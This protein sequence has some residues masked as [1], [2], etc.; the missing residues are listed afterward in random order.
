MRVDPIHQNHARVDLCHDERQ[1]AVDQ[2][3]I[4]ACGPHPHTSLECP[5]QVDAIEVPDG[6]VRHRLCVP[7]IRPL[8]DEVIKV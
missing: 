7:V 4:A 3:T 6:T 5:Q 1:V 2:P 8:D